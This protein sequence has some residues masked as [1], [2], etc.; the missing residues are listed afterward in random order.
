MGERFF[1]WCH[2]KSMDFLSLLLIMTWLENHI[3]YICINI[4]C[5]IMMIHIYMDEPMMFTWVTWRLM[6]FLGTCLVCLMLGELHPTLGW[7]CIWLN[8]IIIGSNILFYLLMIYM[9][10]G[11]LMILLWATW[12]PHVFL[13]PYLV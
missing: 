7:I 1:L 13:A 8:P 2:M 12:S 6:I 3:I 11:V 4:P 9:F 5:Y 10:M